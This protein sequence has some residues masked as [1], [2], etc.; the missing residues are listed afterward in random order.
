[1]DD[2]RKPRKLQGRH[3]LA[4]RLLRLP[5]VVPRHRR[6]PVRRCS[7]WSSSTARRSPTSSTAARCDIGIIEGGLCNAENVHVLREFRSNCK[8]LVAI[9]ACAINGGLPAQ[10]NHLDLR[11]CLQEVY[12]DRAAALA[13]GVIPERSR[14][15]AAA[16]QGAP[17]P[18]G[19]ARSTT[20]SPAA[21]R[22]PTPSGS[23]S[24]TSSPGATPRARPRPDPLRLTSRPTMT[25]PTSKPPTTPR[26]C[27]A[28][29]ST[30]SRAS[31][32]TAR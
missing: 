23:S 16:R 8:M 31:R 18:R 4:R 9:G 19:G 26:S 2:R 21:R 6:A 7:S 13:T 10:R 32:A 17:A 20:S 1:M 27:A 25:L 5:H 29:R 28:S 22:R 14:A 12:R 30:R 3:D 11:D 24:P 15:A